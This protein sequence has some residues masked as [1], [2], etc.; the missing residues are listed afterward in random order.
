MNQVY[1]PTMMRQGRAGQGR[2][3]QGRAE[4][5]R[6]GQGR[7]EQERPQCRSHRKGQSEGQWNRAGAQ[8]QR[9]QSTNL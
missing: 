3:E 9:Q 7:K 2:A 5:G 4:Q 6:A 8:G 1:N